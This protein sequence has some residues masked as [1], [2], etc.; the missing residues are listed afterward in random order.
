VDPRWQAVVDAVRTER[1]ALASFMEHGVL[2]ATSDTALTLRFEQ[3]FYADAVRETDHMMFLLET[4]RSQYPQLSSVRV[5]VGAAP[6]AAGQVSIAEAASRQRQSERSQ[7]EAEALEDPTVKLAMQ[8][9]GGTVV[10]VKP[11]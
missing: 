5:D 8:I 11:G 9:F 7:R 10:Q 4:A 3:A 6:A 1:P 2:V